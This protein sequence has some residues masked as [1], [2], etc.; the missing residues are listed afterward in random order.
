MYLWRIHQ[1]AAIN[2]VEVTNLS[3][4]RNIGLYASRNIFDDQWNG[5]LHRARSRS[6]ILKVE[7]EYYT[8]SSRSPAPG[9]FTIVLDYTPPTAI[10]LDDLPILVIGPYRLSLRSPCYPRRRSSTCPSQTAMSRRIADASPL[11]KDNL[12]PQHSTSVRVDPLSA[13]HP[14]AITFSSFGFHCYEAA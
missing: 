1:I 3:F 12:F 11:D 10:L 13:T 5:R 7:D 8:I 6:A 4:P 9:R 2:G 14:K